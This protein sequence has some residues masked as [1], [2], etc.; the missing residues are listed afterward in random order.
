MQTVNIMHLVTAWQEGLYGGERV[1]LNLASGLNKKRFQIIVVAFGNKE[2]DMPL[3]RAAKDN[4]IR[5]DLLPLRARYDIRSIFDIKRLL[6]KYDVAI[7]H[8]HGYKSD[9]LGF[10][11][12]VFTKVKLVTTLHGWWVGKEFKSRFHN[13]LDLFIV[14]Y[15]DRVVTV[16][17]PLAEKL[18]RDKALKVKTIVIP[19]CVDSK[20]FET[21]KD[22][23][24]IRK[25]FNITPDAKIIG[26]VSRLTEE[27]GHSYLLDAFAKMVTDFKDIVLLIVGEGPLKD[28]LIERTRELGIE[29]KVVFAGFRDDVADLVAMMDILVMPSIS[30]GLPMAILEAMAAKK[31]IVASAVGGIPSVIKDRETGILI[32]PKD[33]DSICEALTCLLKDEKLAL[34]IA[35]NA[36]KLLENEF[37][38]DVMIMKYENLYRGLLD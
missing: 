28:S 24:T 2:D 27:K 17:Q 6:K 37:T 15:F 5:I 35:A 26:A 13:L 11:A 3:L 7:L 34:G 23:I 9:V 20:K 1:V 33:S 19:N 8:C 32:K 38:V 4:N 25:N 36:R 16:S 18:S 22:S 21:A 12:A 31:P 14:R 30:E 29:D 10:F